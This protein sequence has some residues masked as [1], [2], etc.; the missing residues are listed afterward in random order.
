M[1]TTGSC[2]SSS[3]KRATRSASFFFLRESPLITKSEFT[4]PTVT[5]GACR[6]STFVPNPQ[7]YLLSPPRLR[8]EASDAGPHRR[9]RPHGSECCRRYQDICGQEQCRRDHQ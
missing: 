9:R 8:K 5:T 6:S 1:I 3:A 7:I 2:S 4:S